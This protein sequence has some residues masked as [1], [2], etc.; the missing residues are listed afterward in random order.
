LNCIMTYSGEQ[1]SPLEPDI[2]KIH[3]EDIAHAL[4]LM[5]RAGGHIKRFLSVAQH[6]INCAEEAKARGFS[7]RV[8]LGCL[9]HN[10]GEAYIPGIMH[11]DA[12]I[13]AKQH[14]QS[15]ICQKFLGDAPT[16]EEF[17]QIKQVDDDMLVCEL[18]ALMQKPV[19]DWMPQMRAS[20]Q[21][22][23]LDF[24]LVEQHFLQLFNTLAHKEQDSI[25]PKRPFL[26]VG[27]D[28]S[29]GNW[30]AVALSD[31]GH[32]ILFF[33]TIYEAC[34]HFKN[35]DSLLVDMP[36]GLSE[37]KADTRPDSELRRK[38]KGKASSVFNTPC[39]QAVYETEYQKASELNHRVLG[40]RLSPLSFALIPKIREI[41]RFL[42]TNPEWKNRLL[43]SHPEYCFAILNGGAP[44]L[45]RKR[46]SEG[47]KTRLS[48]LQR[49]YPNSLQAL[50]KFKSAYP[51]LTSCKNDFLD[52]LAMAVVGGIGL[53]A[54]F[55]TVP[56][57]PMLDEKGIKMQFT[58]ARIPATNPLSQPNKETIAAMLEAE[59][60][61]KDPSTKGYRDLDALFDD[62][63][64]K[65]NT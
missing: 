15:L 18:N 38:L 20:L 54:G 62:L 46:T 33:D 47:A 44:V 13:K 32:D 28:G 56:E 30:L 35:A 14:L 43:E 10:A 57:A 37:S 58:G 8:Q 50:A 40:V 34:E 3:I 22:E 25:L 27:I 60:I 65:N 6:S 51:K 52:A 55:I 5:C 29:K 45:K 16:N 48:I 2:Q 39:R 17:E 53:E 61:A 19:F 49:Y 1:F 9:L 26:S 23:T 64:E 11:P 12:Y 31:Q 24:E 59:R 7:E 36:I 63:N 4:S 41:D 42:Q 21:F